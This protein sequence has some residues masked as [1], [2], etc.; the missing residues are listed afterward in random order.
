VLEHHSN[1]T[2]EKETWNTRLLSENWDAPV[3]FTTTVQFLET[4]FAGG[5]R[6][7]RRLHQLANA[8]I[9][10]DEIQTLPIKTVHLFN[11]AINFLV[12]QCGSTVVNCTATQPLLHAVCSKKGAARLTG[13]LK[14]SEMASRRD[15]LFSVLRRAEVLDCRKDGGWTEREIAQCACDVVKDSGSALVIVNTKAA[16]QAL[17]DLCRQEVRTVFHLSTNMCPVHRMTI[18][19]KIKYLLSSEKQEP[20]VCVSTQLIEAGVDIDFGAVV[21]YLAGLDSIAQAAGRCNRNGRR[22]SGRVVIV[23]PRHESLDRLPDIKVGKQVAERVLDEYRHTP[24]EFDNDLLSPKTMQRYY[25]YYFFN[26]AHEMAYPVSSRDIGHDDDLLTMLSTN[27]RAVAAYARENRA[28]PAL[29]LRQSF[30][31]AGR[32]FKVIDAPTEGIIVP[33]GEEGRRIIAELCAAAHIEKTK[34]LLREA[35]RYS[36][37]L[38]PYDLKK[39]TDMECIHETHKGS[40]ILYLDPEYYSGDMGVVYERKQLMDCLLA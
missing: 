38:Y 4:L 27:A 31:S 11:N 20:V 5:T 7:V 35:Q 40:G 23:N 24:G 32:A 8:V 37:N 13:D 34:Q 16:A 29:S 39:L 2:P 1:L 26:R 18:L 19:E 33:Y 36:V 6:G 3:I 22:P 17:Y 25:E 15:E 10:L 9:I 14:E 28:A 21:R 12:K 30:K